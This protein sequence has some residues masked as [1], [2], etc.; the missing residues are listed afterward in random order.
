MCKET[1]TGCIRIHTGGWMERKWLLW[2]Y[3][4]SVLFL[5]C[6]TAGGTSAEDEVQYIENEW[7]F[8]DRSMDVSHGIPEDATGVLEK[9]RRTRTLRVATEP[10]FPPQEFIDPTKIGRN[11]FAGS[12]IELAYLIADHMGATLEIVPMDFADVLPAVADGTCDLAIS[13]LSYTPERAMMYELS[14]G[15]YYSDDNAGS[16]ILVREAQL[17][18]FHSIED[19]SDKTIAAQSGSVQESLMAENFRSYREFIRLNS[20]QDRKSVV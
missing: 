2:V 1:D 15:Y 5:L 19:F 6:L 9:I 12:D 11:R 4:V 16:G 17:D 14:R 20:L 8:V 3:L 13:A 10:Y 18:V 7:N